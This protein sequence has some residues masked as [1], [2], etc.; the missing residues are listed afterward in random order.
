M[1]ARQAEVRDARTI[2]RIEVETWRNTYAGML[3]DRLLLGMSVERQT[4]L[5][6]TLL[7][8]GRGRVWVW[9]DEAGSLQGFGNC[10]PLRQRALGY[11]GEISML[12]VL[13]EAQNQ[14]IG[15]QLLVSMFADLVQ[16]GMRSALIWVL[17]VNPARYFYERLG[18][19]LIAT[20]SMTVGSGPVDTVAYVWNDLPSLLRREAS[21]G[22]GLRLR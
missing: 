13:P 5:W 9:A 18:G 10:G 17:R 4:N 21:N 14:G 6:S 7:R 16:T 1:A 3:S 2:A 22:K 20:G 8:H 12:Y 11:E 19:K 15:R